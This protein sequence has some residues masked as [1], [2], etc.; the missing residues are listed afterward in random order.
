MNLSKSNIQVHRRYLRSEGAVFFLDVK[1]I[2][3]A[4]FTLSL[5]FLKLMKHIYVFETLIVRDL[6]APNSPFPAASLD[7]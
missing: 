5:N 2:F 7:A 3:Q 1:V 6:S 4:A